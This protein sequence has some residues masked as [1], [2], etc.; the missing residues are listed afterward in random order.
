MACEPLFRPELLDIESPGISELVFGCIQVAPSAGQGRNPPPIVP[1]VPERCDPQTISL[2]PSGYSHL[3]PY[4]LCP[5]ACARYPATAQHVGECSGAEPAPRRLLWP[6]PLPT[7]Q[8]HRL[9]EV[10]IDNRMSMYQHI[11]LSGGTTM[12]PGLPTRMEKDLR[13]MYVQRVLKARSF[14]P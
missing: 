2:R 10:D 12:F 4:Q 14:L 8:P 13:A 11:V 6:H 3:H 9:Q 7:P 5:S 1:M